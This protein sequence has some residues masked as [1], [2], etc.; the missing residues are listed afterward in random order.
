[1]YNNHM[2]MLILSIT[3]VFLLLI[4]LFLI[5]KIT[6]N[7]NSSL[8]KTKENIDA[9]L[10]ISRETVNEVL[11]G[12]ENLKNEGK[13]TKDS[14]KESIESYVKNIDSL[15]NILQ[16]PKHRG[17]LGEFFL[18]KTLSDVF[19]PKQ[20]KTQYSLDSG[21]VDAVIC[22]EDDL[23]IPIDAKF[24]LENY[25]KMI[26][27]ETLEEKET[28]KKNL[29][30]DL[31]KRID[32]T[33]KYIQPQNKTTDFVLMYIPSETLYYDLFTSTV[34][35]DDL[36]EYAFKKKVVVVS[37]TTFYAYVQ[38]IMHG[39]RSLNIEKRAEEIQKNAKKLKVDLCKYNILMVKL[40]KNLQHAVANFDEC[41]HTYSQIDKNIEKI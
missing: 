39:L 12:I 24:S 37:P 29:K 21:T 28:C 20:Y 8:I 6:K 5:S 14:I 32:E 10:K 17:N 1:M 26:K 7:N 18:E 25:K 23:V 33:A 40:G 15:Q 30:M 34:G 31:K 4:I 27:A 36:I 3:G 9:Q 11:R 22:V 13:N 2:I 16:N 38:T 41:N 19:S 35:I